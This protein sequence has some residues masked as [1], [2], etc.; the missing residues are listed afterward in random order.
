LVSGTSTVIVWPVA[1]VPSYVGC[2]IAV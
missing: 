2:V 1:M